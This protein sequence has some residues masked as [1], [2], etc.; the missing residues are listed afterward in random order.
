MK[1]KFHTLNK[2]IYLFHGFQRGHLKDLG[3]CFTMEIKIVSLIIT[4][5]SDSFI[6]NVNYK[7]QQPKKVTKTVFYVVLGPVH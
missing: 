5:H 7:R 2:G 6:I 4:F 3:F 1:K